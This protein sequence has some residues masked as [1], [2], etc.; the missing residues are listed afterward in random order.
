MTTYRLD[1]EQVNKLI[2]LR[3]DQAAAMAQSDDDAVALRCT[4]IAH[5]LDLLLDEIEAKKIVTPQIV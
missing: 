3:R 1:R 4:Y 2:R 5:A